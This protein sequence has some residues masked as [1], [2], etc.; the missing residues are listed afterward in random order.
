[1]IAP[2]CVTDCCSNVIKIVT[3]PVKLS[4]IPNG[5][6]NTRAR[7]VSICSL[8]E[9]VQIQSEILQKYFGYCK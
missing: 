8:K 6:H 7:I 9:L 2:P 1:M 5:N 3:S 4:I